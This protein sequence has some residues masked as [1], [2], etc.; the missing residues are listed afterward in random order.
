MI[1]EADIHPLA[2]RELEEAALFY[3][4]RVPGLGER[5]L[6]DIRKAIELIRFPYSL[7]YL[8]DN[9]TVFIVAVAHQKREPM[10]WKDRLPS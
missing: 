4:Q 6:N 9:N 2:S 1:P 5:I 7:F 3:D 10:Y 8:F